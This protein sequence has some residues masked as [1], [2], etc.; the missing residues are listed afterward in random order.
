MSNNELYDIY[1]VRHPGKK[2][3]TWHSHHRPPIFCRLDYFLISANL[4]NVVTECGI[5]PG[6]LSD[7]SA[8]TLLLNLGGT[9]KGPGYF[10]LNNSILLQPEYKQKVQ[11][12]IRE[13]VENNA[14][15]NPN[16]MWELIK[17]SVRNE[18]I[19]CSSTLKKKQRRGRN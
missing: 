3:F 16:T 8:I 5:I 14:G 11:D 13:T 7:H 19:R 4:L 9:V 10:K 18:A 12:S 2:Q 6:F 1:R 17:G 15:C